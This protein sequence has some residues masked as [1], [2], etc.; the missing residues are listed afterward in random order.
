[1][2]TYIDIK[3]TWRLSV[4]YSVSIYILLHT[5]HDNYYLK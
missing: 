2:K 1:M 3:L 4:T 5:M